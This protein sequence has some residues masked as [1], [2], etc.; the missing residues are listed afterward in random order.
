MYQDELARSGETLFKIRG[1]YLIAL[2]LGSAAI[3]WLSRDLG[4]FDSSS[5]DVAWFWLSLAVATAGALV[6]IVT[7][8]YAAP[9]T[10]GVTKDAPVAAELHTTGPYSLVRNQLYLGRILHFTRIAM[11][12][13]RWEFGARIVRAAW[14][15]K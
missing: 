11:L 10:S 8:G 12:S 5:A 9:G 14:G 3:A 7:S 2:V 4:P 15:E 1:N 13:G 6:R